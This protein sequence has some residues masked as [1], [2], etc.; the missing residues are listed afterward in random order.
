MKKF[1]PRA[2]LAIVLMMSAAVF[3]LE[4][5]RTI[6]GAFAAAL[7]LWRSARLGFRDLVTYAKPLVFIF[8]FLVLSQG[9]FYPGTTRLFGS[10][11][12]PEGLAYGLI[13]CVRV[14]TLACTLPFL[15]ATSTIEELVLGL[16][17]LGLPYRT[18]YTATTALNQVP[19]LRTDIASIVA[20][21]KLRGCAAFE[22]G[23]P[24]SKLK[25]YPA[26]VVPLVM[27]SMRRASL[28]GTAMDARAFGSSKT[29][30]SIH[31]LHFKAADVFLCGGAFLILGGL[32]LADRLVR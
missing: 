21:Q 26:L 8:A 29:R 4:D 19:I 27:S 32:V 24:L 14:M 3:L 18:A 15:L 5:W 7:L 11:L 25:A 10:P 2:K 28:M 1:D 22:K 9:F 30:T 31:S 16:T 23:N 13:L 6:L 12:K 17:K 20:A